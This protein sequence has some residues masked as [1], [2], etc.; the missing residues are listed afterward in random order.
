MQF[1]IRQTTK[2]VDVSGTIIPEGSVV[3]MG[4]GP[5]NRDEEKF[6]CPHSFELDRKGVGAHLAFG[7]GVHHCPGALLGR[8]EMISSFKF[9]VKRLKNITL[10]KPISEPVHNFSMFFM[11]MASLDIKFEK[12]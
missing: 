4:Y 6:S 2:D 3:L 5:A 1:L 11:P 8:Q 12:R 10:Q 9:L 7:S